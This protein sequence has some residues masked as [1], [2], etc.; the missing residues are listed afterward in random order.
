VHIWL[1]VHGEWSEKLVHYAKTA[2]ACGIAERQVRVA[3]QQAQILAESMKQFA[4]ALGF[5]PADAKVRTAMG[6]SLRL[7]QGGVAA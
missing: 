5:N 1:K 6:T 4:I 2:I 3:E 7:V